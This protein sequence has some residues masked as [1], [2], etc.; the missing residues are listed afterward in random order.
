MKLEITREQLGKIHSI[1]CADW[2]SKIEKFA[3]AD[4]FSLEIKFTEKQINEM[5]EACDS[6]QLPIVKEIFDVLDT[7][8]D[9]KTL[10][11]AIKKLGEKDEEAEQ[12]KLLQSLKVSDRIL[13]QQEAVCFVR[14]LNDKFKFDWNDS[15]QKKW[16][17]WWWMDEFRFHG[18]NYYGSDTDIPASL[19]FKNQ[20]LSDY[21]GN[22]ESYKNICKRFMY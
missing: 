21:A 17:I 22:N 13:A 14:A 20:E 18:S 7:W 4:P 8:K 11:D 3:S 6:K 10:E 9:I 16:R 15:N 19:C 5:I 12:L 1:A 2:K